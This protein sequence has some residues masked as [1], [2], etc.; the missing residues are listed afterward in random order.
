M[1]IDFSYRMPTVKDDPNIE[2]ATPP[3]FSGG[4]KANAMY[5]VGTG[6]TA[7]SK[8]KEAAWKFPPLHGDA[9]RRADMLKKWARDYDA[10]AK[11]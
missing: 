6:I 3:E 4:T 7:K 5:A 10:K 2:T 1:A 9:G 8:D 11:K